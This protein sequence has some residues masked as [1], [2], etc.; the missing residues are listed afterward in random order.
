MILLIFFYQVWCVGEF[1]LVRYDNRCIVEIIIRFFDTFEVLIY[2]FLGMLFV[3]LKE[4]IL[5]FFKIIC[6]LMFFILKVG[7]Y[8]DNVN[9]VL[10]GLLFFYIY[11]KQLMNL[12]SLIGRVLVFILKCF[13]LG[14]SCGYFFKWLQFLNMRKNIL[15]LIFLKNFFIFFFLDCFYFV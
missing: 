10:I 7:L 15:N 1:C 11:I 6:M 4:E 13:K 2:E 3:N 9:I 14:F 5:N 12:M 8:C